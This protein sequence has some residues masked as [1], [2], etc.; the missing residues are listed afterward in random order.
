MIAALLL[1]AAASEP[2]DVVERHL[3]DDADLALSELHRQR[4]GSH[5]LQRFLARVQHAQH[6]QDGDGEDDQRS[7]AHAQHLA[8]V[9]R[10]LGLRFGRREVLGG[11]GR[12]VGHGCTYLS[13]SSRNGSFTGTGRAERSSQSAAE[14]ERPPTPAKAVKWVQCRPRRARSA[15]GIT[16]Q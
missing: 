12:M 9:D 14:M 5:R 10:F 8:P 3:I 7:H 2:V 11:M 1:A 13:A 15:A 6:D 16:T 4:V